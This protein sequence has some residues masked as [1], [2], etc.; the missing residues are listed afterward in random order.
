MDRAVANYTAARQVA[1]LTGGEWVLGLGGAR[2]TYDVNVQ[3]A[4]R[5]LMQ[6]TPVTPSLVFLC[7]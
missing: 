1:F 3:R 2:R 4:A 6:V 7:V 5:P